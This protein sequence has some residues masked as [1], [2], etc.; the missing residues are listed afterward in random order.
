MKVGSNGFEVPHNTLLNILRENV[1][2]M[3]D[4]QNLSNNTVTRGRIFRALQSFR[5]FG[6]SLVDT[7]GNLVIAQ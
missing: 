1:S 3:F 6:D 7:V 5:H 4:V 2:Q